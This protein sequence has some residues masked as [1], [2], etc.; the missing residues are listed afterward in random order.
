MIKICF[1]TKAWRS[2]SAWQAQAVVQ[3]IAAAGG[4]VTFVAPLAE[5]ASREPG[6]ANLRRVVLPRERVDG[7]GDRFVR[8]VASLRRVLACW[9]AVAAER[10][11]TRTFV[12]TIPDP[13]I[14]TLPLFAALRLSGARIVFLVHDAKPHAWRLSPRL[15]TLETGAHALSYRLATEIVALSEAVREALVRDF[16]L[17]PAKVHVVPH[18]SFSVGEDI[19]PLPGN[20]RLLQFGT[21]RRNKKILDVIRGITLARQSDRALRLTIAGEP[22]TPELDYWS[23]CQAAI[24]EDPEGFEVFARF[25]KDEEIPGLIGRV[26]GFVL[27]Y[28]G[29]ESQSGVGILAG[30]NGRPVI[31]TR[32]GGLA[33][34]TAQGLCGE[35]IHGAVTPQSVAAAL[36]AFRSKPA[37]YWSALGET[38]AA[39]LRKVMSWDQI[40]QAWLKLV[41]EKSEGRA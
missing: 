36:S 35:I 39:T 17:S 18:G 2:G 14:F 9:A 31:G 41:D 23:E 11:H 32:S 4:H 38:G 16:G 24:A 30:V 21:L 15:R 26:D 19:V 7:A 25:I 37:E 40:G 8:V 27:A 12:V 20:G 29:F 6:H 3:S 1:L 33:E 22:H 5:P 28:E 13:L 34:L 10:F